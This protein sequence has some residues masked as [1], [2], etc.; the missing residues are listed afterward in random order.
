[1]P[2]FEYTVDGIPQQTSEHKLTPRAI[3]VNAGLNPSERYLIQLHGKDQQS[4]KDAMDTAIQMHEKAKFIT[5]S[6]GPTAVS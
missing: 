4:Y 6:V 5:A 1:M 2:Q 3:L